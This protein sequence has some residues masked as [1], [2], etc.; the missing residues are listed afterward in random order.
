MRSCRTS[1]MPKPRSPRSWATMS[2]N[3]LERP[4][5]LWERDRVRAPPPSP[6]ACVNR[7]S[8]SLYQRPRDPVVLMHQPLEVQVDERALFDPHLAVDD[9]QLHIRRLA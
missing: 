4:L 1:A 8:S 6:E 5:S 2:T 3:P 9:V 7:C